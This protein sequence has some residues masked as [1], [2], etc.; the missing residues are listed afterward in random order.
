M[1][2]APYRSR[3]FGRGEGGK[4]QKLKV[5]KSSLTGS[6]AARTI[7]FTGFYFTAV[8]VESTGGITVL[9]I[10]ATSGA[11]GIADADESSEWS[12]LSN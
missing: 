3:C 4:S 5:K 6:K 2:V 8:A 7:F 10:G 11:A 12:P 9:S 1:E